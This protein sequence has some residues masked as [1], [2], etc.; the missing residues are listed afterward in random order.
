L[1][2]RGAIAVMIKAAGISWS[3]LVGIIVECAGYRCG[4]D[5]DEATSPID[6]AA[7]DPRLVDAGI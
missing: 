1:E 7:P 5:W 3:E 2:K 6:C 4:V